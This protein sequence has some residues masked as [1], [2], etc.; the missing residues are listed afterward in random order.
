MP[1]LFKVGGCVRDRLLGVK[2]K[3]IDFVFVLDDLNKTVEEGFQEM[4]SWMEN[5]GFTIFLSVPEMYT[6]RAK[7]P[8]DHKFAKLDADFVMARKE[9]GYE[10]GTRRPVLELGTLEDDLVRRDFTVNAMAEDEDGNIIDM[11]NGLED[12]DFMLLRTPLDPKDTFMDDPLRILRALRFVIT[13]GF[14]MYVDVWEAIQQPHILA[15]LTQTVSSERIRE[16]V[17]KMMAVDTPRTIRLLI[18][19]DNEVPGFLEVV[20]KEGLWLKPTFEKI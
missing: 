2:T 14:T 8:P 5:E 20:F 19:I 17:L 6:I 9:T 3:D 7:F 10:E 1:K 12:L 16:E 11:F 15:K 4:K 18:D 13:K